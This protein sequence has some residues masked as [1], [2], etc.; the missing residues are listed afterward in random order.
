MGDALQAIRP[1]DIA[2]WFA[3][4]GYRTDASTARI[5]EKLL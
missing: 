4:S 3:H 5:K 2:G 1:G